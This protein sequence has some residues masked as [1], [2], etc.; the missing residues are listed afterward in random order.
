M[1]PLPFNWVRIK[2]KVG[3]DKNVTLSPIEVGILINLVMNLKVISE[4]GGTPQT[5]GDKDFFDAE[6]DGI[7]QKLLI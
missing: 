6:C 2:A 4:N 1:F 7:L 3:G 5:E